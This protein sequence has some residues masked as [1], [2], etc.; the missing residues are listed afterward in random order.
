MELE[1]VSAPPFDKVKLEESCIIVYSTELHSLSNGAGERRSFKKKFREAFSS[2]S[3]L[4]KRISDR[5]AELI[6]EKGTGVGL[7]SRS[8][9]S[10]SQD[11]EFRE[12]DWE[13]I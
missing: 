12:L 13:I 7:S 10:E 8:S 6:E 3:R 11:M 2:K 4:A 9:K 5:H 1:A